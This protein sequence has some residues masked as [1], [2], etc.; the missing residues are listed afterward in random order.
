M[1]WWE[2]METENTAARMARESEK[3]RKANADLDSA[4][5]KRMDAVRK[6]QDA[7]KTADEKERRAK[8][9]L[10]KPITGV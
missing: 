9:T 7:T 6:Q 3:R 4:R 1:R 5:R 8:A 2:F 10:A